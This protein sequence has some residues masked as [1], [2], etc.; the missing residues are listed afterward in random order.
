MGPAFCRR[1]ER[2]G[3][4]LIVVGFRRPLRYHHDTSM[5]AEGFRDVAF[6]PA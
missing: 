3:L 5:E 1:P 6:D 2:G 4:L